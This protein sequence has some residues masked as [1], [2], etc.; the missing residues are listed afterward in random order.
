MELVQ[1]NCRQVT[2]VKY[3]NW[4]SL[5]ILAYQTLTLHRVKER[6]YLDYEIH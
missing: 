4:I 2:A 3:K 1:F 5:F 6:N